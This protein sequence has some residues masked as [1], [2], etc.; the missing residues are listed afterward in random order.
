MAVQPVK[1]KDFTPKKKKSISELKSS[2]GLATKENMNLATTNADKK[3][4]WLIMPPAFEKALRIPGFPL[5]YVSIVCGHSNTGKTTL[6]NCAIAAAQRQGDIPVI[7]DTENNFDFKYAMSCGLKAE[8]VYGDVE[9]EHVDPE[10]GEVTVTV[11]NRIV[12]YD[13]DFIYYNSLLLAEKY[14]NL[15]Y[16]AMKETKTKRKQAVIEDIAMVMNDLL[17]RQEEGEIDRGLVFIWD[18]IGSIGC[19]K[20][21]KTKGNN[22]F[23]AGTLSEVFGNIVNSRIP[24]SRKMAYPYTNT[25]IV[26]NKIWLDNMTVMVGPPS[27]KLKGGHTFYYGSRL[28]ILMGGQLTSGSKKLVAASKGVQYNYGIETKM[29]TLKNHLP[30]PWTITGEG[31]LCCVP[32]GLVS[33]DELDEWKKSHMPMLLKELQELSAAEQAITSEDVTFATEDEDAAVAD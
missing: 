25:F 15:D 9:V 17:S 13:G 19:F 7:F 3:M 20:N 24:A 29:K 2:I 4:G 6:I 32:D 1:K 18:S 21:Y 33:P 8:P 27:L 11:E 28:I 12:N 16:T 23:D 10:T 30:A 14:G 26:I 22:M 31:T 5:G